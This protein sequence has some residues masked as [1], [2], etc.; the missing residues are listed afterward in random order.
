MPRALLVIV[1]W[2]VAAAARA[3]DVAPLPMTRIADGIYVYAAPYELATPENA[4]GI[5]N[6]GFI[7]GAD[8]VAVI[9]TGGSYAVGQRLLA[10]VRAQTERPVRYVVNTHVHPDHVLGNAAFLGLDAHFVGHANLPQALA[11][12][13]LSYLAAT[14]RLI[15]DAAFAGTQAIPPDLLVAD[16]LTLDLGDR[17]ILLEAWPTAHSNTDLTVFDEKTGTWFLGDLVFSGHVPA[18]DGSLRGWLSVLEAIAA[19]PAGRIVPGH[20]PATMPWPQAAVPTRRYL[21][22]LAGD[23]RRLIAQGRTMRD[24]AA[25][26]AQAEREQWTLFD[27]FNGRNATSA[28]HELE[29]E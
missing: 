8:A 16:R 18:L 4:D 3:G 22:Q 28:F 20:G 11:D 7:V 9:D 1:I 12:R 27:E 19:R 24:A 15:G 21:Q 29:W 10:A 13:G 25:Q 2:L 6:L 17:T 26:A 14:A 23:I 5:G